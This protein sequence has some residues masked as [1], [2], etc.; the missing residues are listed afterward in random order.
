MENEDARRS[1]RVALEIPIVVTGTDCMGVAF[2]EQT[3]TTT[4]GRHGAKI[5]LV[6]KLVPEQE[7]NIRCLK[8]SCESD[9][10]I[11]GQLGSE[12]EAY[13]YGVELVETEHN[14]WGIEFPKTSESDA[15]VGRVLLECVHCHS[16]E[17]TY[18]DEF[19][20]EVLETNQ[21][22]SRHCR[23]CTDA[24]MWKK[25]APR[26]GAELP[27]PPPPPEARPRRTRNDRKHARLDLKVDVCIRHPQLGEEV[28]VTV[29]VSRGGFRFKSQKGYGEGW[30]IEAALPFS[31]VGGNIF[32]PARIV[33]VG[34]APGE[35]GYLYGVMYL[36]RAQS[37]IT[38]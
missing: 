7:I 31:R 3:R 12:G 27:P 11:V 20:L 17:L 10:R 16:Q 30:V 18:L 24:S 29:N 21:Y 23:R 5:L 2:L 13:Y 26:E 22:L 37:E 32:T 34:E 4:V 1:D 25:S 19:E 15:A 33:Y 36:P 38:I 35:K 9:A 28:T 14:P 6:R 8:T